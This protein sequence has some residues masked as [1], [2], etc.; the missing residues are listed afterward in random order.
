LILLPLLPLLLLMMFRLLWRRHCLAFS[1]RLTAC[2]LGKLQQ[3]AAVA[4]CRASLVE[5][6]AARAVAAAICSHSVPHR[7]RRRLLA[8]LLVMRVL[9]NTIAVRPRQLHAWQLLGA[10]ARRGRLGGRLLHAATLGRRLRWRR[11]HA[12]A[13][14]C[15]GGTIARTAVIGPRPSDI[16]SRRTL[17]PRLWLSSLPRPCAATSLLPCLPLLKRPLL[18]AGRPAAPG[19]QLQRKVRGGVC[20]RELVRQ[21]GRQHNRL[22]LLRVGARGRLR[23]LEAQL[24]GGEVRLSKA[25]KLFVKG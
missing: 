22:L 1:W 21:Q 3:K 12:A 19:R 5:S 16:R 15:S 24:R 10:C 17:L 6:N 20:P 11:P 25:A 7:Q 14:H 8:L 13:A 9:R 23:H 18:L 2:A 4:C